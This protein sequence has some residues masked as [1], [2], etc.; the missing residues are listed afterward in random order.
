MTDA[1]TITDSHCHLDFPDFAEELPDVIA[2][3]QQ[4][5]IQR[6][7]TICTKMKNVDQVK[8]ISER[9]DP[10]YWAAGT[11][12]MSAAEEPL[13]SVE[14]LVALAAHPKF[15]GIGETGLDYHYT[16]ESK[17][18]Q[19]ESLLIHIEA[20][21]QTKLPLIIHARAADEDMARILSDEHAKGAYDCV[22][23]CYCSG[24]ELA[25]TATDLGFYLS[26]SGIA[27][28]KN[29]QEVRDIFAAAPVDRVL[30]ETDAPYLAPT[31]FRGKRNEPAY[32]AHTG[33]LGAEVF[34]MEYADFAAQTEANFECLF[35]RAIAT[36]EAA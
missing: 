23:H 34:G 6:M 29:S 28:F 7:V 36:R 27:T 2:R 12:P 17:T 25:K 8:A 3:A 22:M 10:V 11:H 16:A 15:V 5:G 18:I 9:F 20:A 30:L 31:P 26:M 21:R 35:T 33:R 24:P 1:P 19:Q 14:E 32:T 13:V 4:A